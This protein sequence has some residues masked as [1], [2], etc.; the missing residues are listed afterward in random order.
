MKIVF[1]KALLIVLVF[2][3]LFTS[4]RKEEI[5]SIQAPEEETLEADSNISR[6]IE[7]I[8][9]NDGS[10]DN[11]LNNANCFTLKW[12][13]TVIVN[14]IPVEVNSL[15]DLLTVEAI[16][17]VDDEDVDV[18]D[19]NFPVTV[20]KEN[21]SEVIV[22][23]N[24]EL[25]TIAAT[26]NGE[27]SIDPDIECIDFE[28][29]INASRFNTVSEVISTENFSS[30]KQLFNFINSL[31]ANDVVTIDF[32]LTARL[33]DN[34]QVLINNLIDLESM[35]VS[36]QNNC[37]EDDDYDYSDDDCDTCTLEQLNNILTANCSDFYVKDLTRNNIDLE[38]SYDGYI[39]N[40]FDDNTLRVDWASVTVYGTWFASG[41]SN[42]IQVIV[43]IPAL[44]DCNNTWN[45]HEIQDYNGEQKVDF[46]LGN[47]RLRY[48]STCN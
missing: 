10:K 32:P 38:D 33:S 48:I 7:N 13:A 29:P 19:I 39:F 1:N 25:N 42:S 11:I 36:V 27:N 23:N 17:D 8:S 14:T 12:P 47:E 2:S 34:S 45:L 30:D 40:F 41:S 43:N 22:T 6:L 37:D 3:F 4:C 9:L 26:C 18:L 31:T 44:P 16:L 35:I 24:T 15:N 21:H 20:I 5:E 28:Y 46:T